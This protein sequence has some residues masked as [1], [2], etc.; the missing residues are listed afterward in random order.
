[1]PASHLYAELSWD[2]EVIAAKLFCLPMR[3][4]ISTIIIRGRI[5]MEARV[6]DV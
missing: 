5:E 3:S 4:K 2:S 6:I 1:M